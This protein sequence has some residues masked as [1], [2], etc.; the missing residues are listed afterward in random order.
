MKKHIPDN[1][2]ELY[3]QGHS[4]RMLSDQT[5][6]STEWIRSLICED[7]SVSGLK[8]Y[9]KT[10]VRKKE[11]I[12]VFCKTTFTHMSNNIAKYC[13]QKCKIR[14]EYWDGKHQPVCNR[15]IICLR[16]GKD[17]MAQ[18]TNKTARYCSKYCSN[19]ARWER[20]REANK[21]MEE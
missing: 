3:T 7:L 1:L 4:L 19:K 2:T 17:Y 8:D 18:N 15:L 13:S 10:S 16:C 5:G 9:R 21:P 11:A 14:Q 12:C 6:Y 20:W